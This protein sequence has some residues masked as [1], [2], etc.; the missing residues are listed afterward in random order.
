MEQLY[1]NRIKPIKFYVLV[2]NQITDTFVKKKKCY[3]DYN[4]KHGCKPSCID[5][6]THPM[7]TFH[8]THPFSHIEKLIYNWRLWSPPP[9]KNI[10]IFVQYSE[11]YVL[12]LVFIWIFGIKVIDRKIKTEKQTNIKYWNIYIINTVSANKTAGCAEWNR[13]KQLTNEA[14]QSLA[15]HAPLPGEGAV[16]R[17]E[18]GVQ[19]GEKFVQDPCSLSPLS[20]ALC[21][22]NSNVL[23]SDQV[24]S[25]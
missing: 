13:L 19:G 5:L 11:G 17:V 18:G 23:E 25:L 16:Q 4:L 9:H 15:E 14:V 8:A 20:P 22:P 24:T 12:W 3:Q 6:E 21:P 1:I 7:N 2:Y 10:Q